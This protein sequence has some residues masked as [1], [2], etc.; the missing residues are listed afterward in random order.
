MKGLINILLLVS[1]IVLNSGCQQNGRQDRVCASKDR[2][3]KNGFE[4]VTERSVLLN[5]L[6]CKSSD[7]DIRNKGFSYGDD[8]TG[9]KLDSVCFYTV[10]QVDSLTS[11]YRSKNFPSYLLGKSQVNGINCLVVRR[12]YGEWYQT[13][14]LLLYDNDYNITGLLRLSI[15]GGDSEYFFEGKGYF[16]NDSTYVLSS[17][18]KES[19]HS[20]DGLN[21]T[22]ICNKIVEHHIVKKSGEVILLGKTEVVIEC[23]R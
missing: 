19:T 12:N 3:P 21:E 18:T 4:D 15:Y 16:E 7:I 20:D 6:F 13:Q 14:E 17:I 2:M 5:S 11:G 9:L 10:Y 23:P 8:S 22:I 1:A